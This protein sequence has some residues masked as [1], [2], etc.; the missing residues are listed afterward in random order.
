MKTASGPAAVIGIE[1]KG[2][3]R[4]LN[5]DERRLVD[6]LCDQAAI[7]VERVRLADELAE[8][9][10][11]AET[12]HLRSLLFNSISHDLRT[13]LA[14]I[15]GAAT[16]LR[17]NHEG[18]TAQDR[19]DLLDTVQEESERLNRFVG[20]LLDMTRLEAGVLKPS[21]AWMDIRDVVGSALRRA[22]TL[23]ARHQV[24]VEAEPGLP[25]MNLDAILIEQVLVNLLDNAQ[26][27]SDPGS[28]IVMR[29][30]RAG[31]NL[32]IDVIDQGLGIPEAERDLIFDK[33]YRV[34]AGD[35]RQAG[36]GLGLSI[37]KGFVGVH[38][39]TIKALPAPQG[40]GAMIRVTLP[41]DPIGPLPPPDSEG[42]DA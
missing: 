5:A 40:E 42:D 16:S 1:R 18:L 35:R 25:P 15:L 33:F 19:N 4:T 3:E 9:S 13:P 26:K 38:G 27:Y 32:V 37:C 29:L 22:K 2:A 6:A 21:R 41:I 20:N 36:T 28:E 39:G 34:R 17:L 12:E 31:S 14:S 10:V 11:A 7:A 24:R 23:L 30:A 8:A